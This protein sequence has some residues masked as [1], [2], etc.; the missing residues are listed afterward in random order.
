[1][2]RGST[3]ERINWQKY[4]EYKND[5]Y[6]MIV[7]KYAGR[8]ATRLKIYRSMEDNQLKREFKLHKMEAPLLWKPTDR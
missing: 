5:H 3:N 4:I 1:M 8:T 7:V 2:R 6:K